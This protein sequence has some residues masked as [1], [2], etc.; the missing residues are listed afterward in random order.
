[1]HQITAVLVGAGARGR[2]VYGAYAKKYPEEL[3]IVAVAEPNKERRQLAAKDYGLSSDQLYESW[4]QILTKTKIADVAVISTQDRM[5]YAPT[6]KALELGYDVLLEKPMSPSPIEVIDM[7]NASRKHNRLLTVSHV[8][9]YTPFWSKIKEV[10]E[11][12][13]IGS[14]VSIQSSENVGYFHMAHSFVRGNWNKSEET[15]PMIL[16][17]SCHDMDILSWLIDE[18]CTRVSSYG[19]L[20]HFRSENAPDGTTLRC[21]EGCAVERECPYS[22]IR[23]YEEAETH[24]WSRFITNDIT[25]EGIKEALRSGPFGR[26]VYHC[27]NNVVDHQVVNMEFESGSTASFTMSGF[28]HDISRTV[29][30]MGTLGEIRGYMEKNEIVLYPFGKKAIEIPLTVEEGGHGG[31]DE[32][33]MREFLKQVRKGNNIGGQGLT[34]AE[35]SLQSHLMA[36]A[37]EQSRLE[38]GNSV[39]VEEL[40]ARY[41]CSS[42]DELSFLQLHIASTE[43]II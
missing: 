36:F 41:T 18:K 32:G 37:A 40:N 20:L 31:G 35:A 34:S 17:K 14:I 38:G 4:E 42:A 43:I 6:M 30:I 28:S 25:P 24:E 15:S 11:S 33:L 5:H 9:R 13:A 29:Q 12:G 19:S 26:C 22:A 27:D 23:I 3:K 1:M 2:F 21:T 16:Q 8:L 39:V 7:A 10:I